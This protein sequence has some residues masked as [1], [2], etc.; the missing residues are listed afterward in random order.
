MAHTV[1]ITSDIALDYRVNGLITV[2][3]AVTSEEAYAMIKEKYE[4]FMSD[5]L[6]KTNGDFI[7]WLTSNKNYIFAPYTEINLNEDNP[8]LVE[9]DYYNIPRN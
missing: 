4:M 1:L 5:T 8:K 6:N 2:V 7:R 3:H 9:Y